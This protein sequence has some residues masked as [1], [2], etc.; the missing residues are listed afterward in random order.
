MTTQEKILR[1]LSTRVGTRP[2]H[3]SYGSRMYRL[4]DKKA[5]AEASVWF[6]KYAHEDIQRSD[7]TLIVTKA[8]LVRIHGDV[9][10]AQ[11]TLYDNSEIDVEV[12]V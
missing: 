8:K 6:S 12:R 10:E 1:I 3:P 5:D 2:G 11:I 7:P 4:R 9:I